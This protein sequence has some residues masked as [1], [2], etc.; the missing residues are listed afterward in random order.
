[1]LRHSVDNRSYVD[2]ECDMAIK[3]NAKIVILY[4]SI[5]VDRNKCPEML[6]NK[7]IHKPMKKFNFNTWNVEWDYQTVKSAIND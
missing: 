3:E 7:G 5:I 6:R 1:M 2:Y 4:N